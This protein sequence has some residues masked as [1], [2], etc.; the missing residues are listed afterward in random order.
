MIKLYTDNGGVSAKTR[1][2]LQGAMSKQLR[3]GSITELLETTETDN[4]L[5][6]ELGTNEREEITYGT[7]TLGV[8]TVHPND[9]PKKVRKAKAKVEETEED[10][11]IG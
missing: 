2:S 1:K 8:S 10:F 9:K 6:L 11:V 7:I 3:D 5:V 4:V